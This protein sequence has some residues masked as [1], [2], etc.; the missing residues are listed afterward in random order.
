MKENSTH[1]YII[2]RRLRI[3]ENLMNT[4]A[5]IKAL[6]V[7]RSLLELRLKSVN[8]AV[9]SVTSHKSFA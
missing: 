3:S 5:K 2:K 1:A 4:S 7:S 8:D 9:T 6:L